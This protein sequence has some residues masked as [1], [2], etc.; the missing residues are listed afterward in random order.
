MWRRHGACILHLHSSKTSSWWCAKCDSPC[1]CPGAGTPPVTLAPGALIG[2]LSTL[3]QGHLPPRERCSRGPGG[4][5]SVRESAR[6]VPALR[7]GAA[8]PMTARAACF[9]GGRA[10]CLV[11]TRTAVCP[12]G[13]VRRD[14]K[15]LFL[16]VVAGSY[17]ARPG[18][19]RRSSAERGS[20]LCCVYMELQS[21]SSPPAHA[22]TIL[23]G[24]I[25]R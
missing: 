23:L 15:L 21:Q 2:R 5:W 9:Y 14:R 12:M 18:A 22:V 3:L 7:G 8:R 16:C 11:S 10:V 25:F 1:R 4:L 17:T 20:G 24:N 13:G 19:R 6:R